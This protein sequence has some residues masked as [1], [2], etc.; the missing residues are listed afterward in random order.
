MLI[1]TRAEVEALLDLD[2]MVDALATAMAD[3]SA[4]RSR[5]TVRS[6]AIVDDRDGL[7]G[8]LAMPGYVPS[9]TTLMTKLTSV[10]PRNAGTSVPVRQAVIV[11]FDPDDGEP[12]ALL[13]GSYIMNARTAGCSA[14]STRLLARADASTLAVLGSGPQAREHALAVSRVR[15]ISRIRIAGRDHAKAAALAAEV[16]GLV[17]AEVTAVH[18]VEEAC[19]DAD[20]VCAATFA[21]EPV[22]R[23]EWLRPGTHVT[24]IGANPNGR[25]VD[26]ATV[27]DA[28]LCVESRDIALHAVPP[29]RDLTQPIEHG[30]ITAADVRAELGE[31]VAGTVE[32]RT[33]PAQ[34]TLYKSVGLALADAAA[35]ALVLAA[36]RERG[37]GLDIALT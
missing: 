9:P 24:S 8:V 34:I 28:Y 14:L 1:I 29:C 3:L 21:V 4:G 23:R 27:G 35:A 26:D 11:A 13:D 6:M 31:L 33:D 36:A 7:T 20:V 19:A 18:S 2:T 17:T 16:S 30:V 10:F 37:I 22:V 5:E 12:A 15:P 25:E 32:G